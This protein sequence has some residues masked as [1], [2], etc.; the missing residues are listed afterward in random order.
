MLF[1]SL[2]TTCFGPFGPSSGETLF[3]TYVYG[4][5]HRCVRITSPHINCSIIVLKHLM[6]V[7]ALHSWV[8]SVARL[9]SARASW[10]CRGRTERLRVGSVLRLRVPRVSSIARWWRRAQCPA[11]PAWALEEKLPCGTIHH[12]TTLRRLLL[13]GWSVREKRRWRPAHVVG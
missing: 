10:G 6:W 12:S 4:G 2:F 8:A 1:F 3:I 7:N 13:R 11:L 5:R 9:R